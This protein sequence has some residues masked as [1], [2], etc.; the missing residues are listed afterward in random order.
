MP[1]V[2]IVPYTARGKAGLRVILD[3]KNVKAWT[4]DNAER[5]VGEGYVRLLVKNYMPTT[6]V[7]DRRR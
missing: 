6:V 2:D 5:L 1:L 7:G 3:D 4:L